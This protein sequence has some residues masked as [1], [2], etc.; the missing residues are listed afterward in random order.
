MKAKTIRDSYKDY[1]KEA[2]NP[3]SL[4]RYTKIT[5]LF[6]KFLAEKV[7][8]GEEVT[9]PCRLGSVKIQGKK[10]DLTPDEDGVL[11]LPVDWGKTKK[12]WKANPEA[13]KLGT[14]IYHLD[15]VGYKFV[16]SRLNV[17]VRYKNL[18]TLRFTRGNKRSVK[19]RVDAGQF[20][21]IK[22]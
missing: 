5:G 17:L 19:P 20:Y 7:L 9:L 16:W 8:E 6:N 4:S 15:E 12:Y 21:S 1:K 11:H 3:V 14:K 18:Y 22:L 13:A 2:E 10:R